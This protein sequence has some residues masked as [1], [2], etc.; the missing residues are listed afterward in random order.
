MKLS[1]LHTIKTKDKALSILTDSSHPLFPQFETLGCAK[2][3]FGYP[4]YFSHVFYSMYNQH[5]PTDNKVDS[6]VFYSILIAVMFLET[7]SKLSL[8]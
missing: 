6:I 3:A 2:G 5:I 8:L 1:E 7:F 4:K